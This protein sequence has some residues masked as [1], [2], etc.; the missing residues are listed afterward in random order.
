M[1]SFLTRSAFEPKIAAVRAALAAAQS[2][3]DKVS[4]DQ[5]RRT[6]QTAF[7]VL[8][9]ATDNWTGPQVDQVIAG[10]RGWDNW[11]T[12]GDGL[13][14][15][16]GR[17]ARDA[18][19][20]WS[21]WSAQL[22]AAGNFA[23]ALLEPLERKVGELRAQL[24][25]VKRQQ[26]AWRLERDGLEE[27]RAQLSPEVRALY[28]GPQAE[29][30][31]AGVERLAELVG[32]LEAGLRTLRTGRLPDFEDVATMGNPFVGAAGALAVI[33]IAASLY[34]SL[35]AYFKHAAEV[36]RTEYK[37][38]ELKA[39]TEGHADAIAKLRKL[40][41]DADKIRGD[42]ES[43]G[44]GTVVAVVVVVGAVSVGGWL[45]YRYLQKRK[46]QGKRRKRKAK[47]TANGA[48]PAAEAH[49]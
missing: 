15:Q 47:S 25:Q 46:G 9:R 24:E 48:L 29:Q 32:A 8:V 17:F 6:Q 39:T 30:A 31:E 27:F 42:G 36:T 41:N 43:S 38:L 21:R 35:N 11:S 13:A 45:L 14:E 33:A 1:S 37:K 12:Y 16:A 23:S 5:S 4:D 7:D 26:Q 3:I 34:G 19:E 18:G 2:E 44:V 28:W 22:N 40:Q 20:F 10:T 49:A